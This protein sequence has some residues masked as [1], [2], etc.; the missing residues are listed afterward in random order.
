[1]GLDATFPTTGKEGLRELSLNEIIEPADKVAS[2]QQQK[3]DGQERLQLPPST[4]LI[5]N[6]G[7]AGDEVAPSPEQE[8][9][10]RK[11]SLMPSSGPL[12]LRQSP[13][14][15]APQGSDSEDTIRNRITHEL[16]H[17]T[18]TRVEIQATPSPDQLARRHSPQLCGEERQDSPTCHSLASESG[19]NG[20]TAEL[21]RTKPK[22]RLQKRA[23]ARLRFRGSGGTCNKDRP[24]K[25]DTYIPL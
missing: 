8:A 17:A 10:V 23:S 16:P 4:S 7:D 9:P 3:T 6:E 12:W 1:M 20:S 2:S 19:D 15:E 13:V 21:L 25:D 11:Q 18:A 14:F 24:S 5:S 22:S